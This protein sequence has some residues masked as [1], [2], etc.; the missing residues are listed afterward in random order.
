MGEEHWHDI[1]PE[2][3]FA[4]LETQPAG[5]TNSEVVTRR[6]RYG[7]NK[8]QEPKKTPGW[9]RFLSQYHDPLN[10]LLITERP[11]LRFPSTPTIQVMQF[12][13]SPFSQ[14]MLS[15][16]IGKK[17]RQ[18]K[19]WTHSNRW[20]YRRASSVRDGVEQEVPTPLLVPG[21]V[22]RL[23]EGLN[24]PADVRIVES[25]QCKVDES[26]LTG[27]SNSIKKTVG[28][29]PTES[30]LADRNNMAYMGTTVA[31]WSFGWDCGQYWNGDR[32]WSHCK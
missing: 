28:V 15:L 14:P 8:L 25:Y 24:V 18:S 4:K 31:S 23:E 13:S 5:L 20:P 19:P 7:E 26:S 3:T 6:E 17:V 10:Y 16:A 9:L 2:D 21:D 32:T 27:E 29:L 12:S 11:W 30:L 1:S 22:V